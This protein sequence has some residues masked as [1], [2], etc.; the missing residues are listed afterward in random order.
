MVIRKRLDTALWV[1]R[2]F[3]GDPDPDL[4]IDC[5]CSISPEMF[6]VAQGLFHSQ[7]PPHLKN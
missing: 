7:P 5:L 1:Q 6:Q 2:Y 3:E 4:G